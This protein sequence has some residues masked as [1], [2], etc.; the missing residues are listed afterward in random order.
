MDTR[1]A[2]MTGSDIPIPECQLTMHQPTIEEIGLLGE[3]DFFVGMQTITI[4][5]S[6]FAL[7]ESALASISNFQ[8]FMTIMGE[9]ETADKK[10]SVLDV[11]RLI[12]PNTT[13]FITPRSIMFQ[14]ENETHT[15][16]ETNFDA[17]QDVLRLVF[18]AKEGAM[19]QQAFNPA[20]QKAKEI[21]DKLMR[22]RQKVAEQ[23]GANNISVF[24]MYLSILSIGLHIS[25]NELKKMTMYQIYDLME[26]FSLWINWDIDTKIRLAGGKPD[27]QPDNWM[28]NIH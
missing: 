19:D 9:K 27:S 23:K 17:L 26:R 28:K 20:N 8:I 7:D 14:A 2:L 5:K 21:A 16:D 15:V 13:V 22:G 24:S 11:F 6:M 18:C 12:F 10:R 25:I 4:Y 1:L 3:Q